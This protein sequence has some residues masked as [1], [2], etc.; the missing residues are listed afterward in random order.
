MNHRLIP[1]ADPEEWS[2]ALESIPHPPAHTH[3][4]VSAFAASS[5][6]PTFLYV[7]ADDDQVPIVACPLS[8]RGDVGAA[9]VYTPYGFGGFAA[10]RPHPAFADDWRMFAVEQGWVAAYV[11][12]HP[13]LT[14]DLGHPEA[15]LDA[16]TTCYV[17]DLTRSPEGVLAAMS[18]RRRQQLTAWART[19]ADL[20]T[21]R[22][23]LCG[24]FE[25]EADRFFAA[26][27]AASLYRF[28]PDTWH[29]LLRSPVAWSIGV[30]EAGSI[31]AAS[32]FTE[33]DGYVEYLFGMSVDG[34][35]RYS[36]PLIWE[37]VTHFSPLGAS[38]LNLGGGVRPGDGVAEFKRRFGA[39][40]IPAPR[41]CLVFDPAAFTE[42][43]R[44]AGVEPTTDGF[45]PPYRRSP[46]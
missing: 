20:T 8:I 27:D 31:V 38:T 17:L 40:E 12:Q 11:M 23:E 39:D 22:Q 37:A 15:S 44:A 25:R 13:L 34:A 2:A 19:P 35:G 24:F 16:G 6:D 14:A 46:G 30:R 18:A 5:P 42:L 41:L 9:D 4:H 43:S 36:A 28:R 26:R 1:L 21:D 3:G 7:C 29:L 45:F 32:V 33:H 10:R